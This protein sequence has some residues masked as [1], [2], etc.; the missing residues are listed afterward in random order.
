MIMTVKETIKE[1]KK[2]P[3]DCICDC[4]VLRRRSV[5]VHPKNG[6]EKYGMVSIV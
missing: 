1:L 2:Y 3:Q 6:V 4:V 5:K